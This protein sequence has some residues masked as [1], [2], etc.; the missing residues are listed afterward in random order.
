MLRMLSNRTIYT[1]LNEGLISELTRA[2]SNRAC[3]RVVF[4]VL[5]LE[6]GQD[7]SAPQVSNGTLTTKQG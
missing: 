5:D 3:Q 4:R 2:Q 1:I 6:H 7:S